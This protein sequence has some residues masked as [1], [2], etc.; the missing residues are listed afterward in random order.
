MKAYKI[1]DENGNFMKTYSAR[2]IWEKLNWLKHSY[3]CY[4]RYKNC[5]IIEYELVETGKVIDV[6]EKYGHE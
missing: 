5:K 2:K 4:G 6:K 3:V 1:V